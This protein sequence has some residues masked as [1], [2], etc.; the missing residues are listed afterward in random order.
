MKKVLI[1]AAVAAAGAAGAYFINQQS[2]STAYNVLDYVPADTPIFTGQLEPFP[3]KDYL[4]SAPVMSTPNSDEMFD[5]LYAES[6]EKVNFFLNIFKTYQNSI[7]DADLLI[8][9]FGFPEELRAYFY[10]LGLMP[11]MKIEVENPQAVWDLLDKSE[12]ESGFTH[13][14]GTL[15]TV[16][17]R[18]YQL[19]DDS[20]EQKV[21][22]IIA[23]DR[24]L[25]TLTLNTSF[26]NQALLSTALGLT[27]VEDSL[28][29]S[30]VI[31][32][33]IKKYNF[34]SASVGFI[35]HIEI[36]KALTTS[37]GNQLARQ[38][39][40]LAAYFGEERPLAAIQ[41]AECASD[42]NS[43]A[44]NWPRTV[45]GYTNLDINKKEST[46]EMDTIIESKN[47]AVL[48]ALKTIRG[49]IPEYT[50]DVENN[51]FAMGLGID[52]SLLAGSLTDIWSDLQTPTYTCAPLAELQAE[53][54]QSGE[55]I[56]MLSMGA[57]VANGVKGISTA[58]LDY[59]IS[60]INGDPMIENL[61]ALFSVSSDNPELLF[62]SMKMFSPEFQHI[63]LS[64][65]SQPIELGGIFPIPAQLNI[66]PKLAIKGNHL[67]IYN[68]EKGQKAVENLSSEKLSKN[69]VYNFSFDFKKM[70]APIV[71]AAELTGEPLPEEAM[72]LMDYDAR[73]KMG[74]DISDQGLVFDY[75]INSKVSE[76]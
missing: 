61:D 34:D 53:I 25:L 10:T 42:F 46:L 16:N 38:L 41:T 20:D 54:S 43:I 69:G 4:A 57:N 26:N 21:E 13:T 19:S 27:P 12:L 7:K 36:I 5:E 11:V 24:G 58:V 35:N 65:T 2:A 15:Q 39:D 17:Y 76:K 1:I 56:G 67:V 29:K 68:G 18:A 44:E 50:A 48:D 31:E 60:Q 47:Q 14:K 55:S 52:V 51:V 3:L 37:D 59:T 6:T 32:Q 8:K 75:Y 22:L 71:T 73:M 74:F 33:T 45:F 49:Y 66:A 70:F 23:Q 30:G 9:T 63:Q 40:S 62:N 72:F 28:A 64:S